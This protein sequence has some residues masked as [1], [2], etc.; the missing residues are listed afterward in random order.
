MAALKILAPRRRWQRGA[1]AIEFA[2]IFLLFF[3]LFYAIVSYSLAML[4]MQGLTQAAEE[5]VRAA[6]AVNPLAYPSD[7]GYLTSVE[8]TA[9]NRAD[10]ALSWLPAKARQQVVDNN[11]ISTTVNGSV[12]TVTVTYP[13]YATNGLVPTFTIPLIGPVPRLP[14][15]LVGEASLQFQSN[16]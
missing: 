15:N 11:H 6:I 8:T 1:A 2:L 10:A 14:T 9:R 3:V 5:G 7:A 13:N 4:L 16:N 12:I